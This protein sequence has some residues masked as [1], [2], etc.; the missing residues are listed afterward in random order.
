MQVC[1]AQIILSYPNSN[2]PEAPLPHAADPLLI[3]Q[4]LILILLIILILLP[5]WKCLQ[6]PLPLHLLWLLCF[7]VSLM[8]TVE[9]RLIPDI[10]MKYFNLQY[11]IPNYLIK[12]RLLSIIQLL[13]LT[14]KLVFLME[15]IRV[16]MQL[17]KK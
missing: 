14:H 7:R 9:P 5:L 3:F 17:V 12:M 11:L 16:N 1:T 4:L 8:T 10:K 15:L 13:I 6:T 2:N